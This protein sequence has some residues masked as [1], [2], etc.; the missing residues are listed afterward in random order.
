[1]QELF[2]ML[3]FSI[4]VLGCQS[5]EKQQETAHNHHHGHANSH[6]NKRSFEE[7]VA[8]FEAPERAAWQ[9]PDQ[10]IAFLGDLREKVVMDI[11][12]G[13]G[14][15]SFRLAQAGAMVICADVDE[16]FLDYITNRKVEGGITNQVQTRKIGYKSPQLKAEEVDIVLTVNS[17]HH[18]ENRKAY[19][20]EVKEG[21]KP[22]GKLVVI[23]FRK[24]ETPVGPPI[25]MK[26]TSEKV[27]LELRQSGFN[28]IEV[29]NSLLPYQYIVTAY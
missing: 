18:I 13:T 16:R 24:E 21:L 14:Y 2:F 1:M 12:S 9:K 28:H 17:Y 29:N 27:V 5:Q 8:N 11:G 25:E 22:G 15:F 26:I 10:V 3:C 23:D 6:M 4:L 7:L 19:F 20:A